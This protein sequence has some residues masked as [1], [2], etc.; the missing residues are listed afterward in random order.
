MLLAHNTNSGIMFESISFLFLFA[1]AFV[2]WVLLCFQHVVQTQTR[3]S[4]DFRV[5]LYT[6]RPGITFEPQLCHSSS[7]QGP[8]GG[9]YEFAKSFGVI[10]AMTLGLSKLLQLAEVQVRSYLKCRDALPAR[11]ATQAEELAH[12]QPNPSNPFRLNHNEELKEQLSILQSQCLV[13]RELL[14]ELRDSSSSSSYGSAESG[15]E[16]QMLQPS[17]EPIVLWKRSDS[18]AEVSGSSPAAARS[19]NSQPGQNIFIS[20]SHIHINSS[21]YL[22]EN[23]VNVDLCRQASMYTRKQSEFLQVYGQYI[24][25]PKERPMLAGMRCNNILM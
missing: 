19:A 8:S 15:K 20:N 16:H 23:R 4:S 3:G 9:A 6:E 22:T 17:E 14:Q 10:F 5:E 24:T 2:A 13:M 25:G 7:V 1:L 21:F 18:I 12:E 11:S